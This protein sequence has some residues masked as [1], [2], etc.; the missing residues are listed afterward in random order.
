[1]SP[2]SASKAKTEV[3]PGFLES[4]ESFWRTIRGGDGPRPEVAALVVFLLVYASWLAGDWIPGETA[5][6]QILFLAPV[7]ALVVWSCWRAS[8]RCEQTPWLRSFWILVML[9]WGAQLVADLILG[10][11]DIVL[12]DPTFPSLAD[13]FF[14]CFYPLLVLALLRIPSSP[15]TRSQRLQSALDSATVVVGGG[16]AIWYFDLGH[17]VTE[18][19]GSLLENGVTIAYQ[20]GDLVLLGALALVL[21]RGYPEA[22]RLPL[23]LV[24]AGLLML[25]VADT[26]YGHQQLHGTYMPGDPVDTLY[27]LTATPFVLAAASQRR[28]DATGAAARVA[29]R[30]AASLR[31]SPLPLLALVGG[32]G[33][34]LGT[35]WHDK[36]FPDLS[37]LVFVLVLGALAVCRQY[38]A[39]RELVQLQERVRTIVESVADGIV[40]FDE[41]GRII[42]VNPAAEDAFQ[43]APGELEGT[44]VE[45]IFQGVRWAEMAPLLGV[46]GGDGKTVI[47][48]RR[49][50]TGLRR[51]GDT[52]PLEMIVTDAQLDGERVLIAVGQDVGER[53]RVAAALQESERRFRGIFDHAGVGIAFSAFEDGRPRIVD[54]NAAFS[55]T[56][57]YSPEELRGDDF[58]LI[59][60]PDDLADMAEMGAAV[61]AGENYIAR[62]LRCL[63][64]DGTFVWGSL[65]V[66][67]LRDDSGQPRFAIGMLEDITRRKE[68]ERVK[69]EFVSVVGHEL[70]TPLTSIRGSLGLLEG[71]V[72]GELPEEASQM[73][74]TAVSN[75][76]RLVRLI[77]DIL[78]IERID[79]GRADLELESVPATALV[80]QSIEVVEAVADE[81]G[82]DL[83]ARAG[84]VEVAADPDR[85]V[86]TLT[87]LIGNAIKFSERGG[88]V[89]VT[90]D[91]D[92]D[93]AVFSVSDDGRGIP[94]DRLGAIFERFTQ[95][96]ASDARE[97]GGTGLGLAI[98]RS[99]VEH[100]GGRI[101]AESKEGV[102]STFRFALPLAPGRA[103]E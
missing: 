17:A 82:I 97:K 51:D 60:H 42:W 2:E 13:L 32:T 35:Q 93:Q 72:M 50:L 11:Y 48:R 78:D 22:L 74:T 75:T 63:H 26:V 29:G 41:K 99:I 85:I 47:G 91:L 58:S 52:F 6:L 15:S 21:V 62:E 27:V 79:S 66:S 73:L 89:E 5:K 3:D 28:I 54:A 70:R 25:I 39:Q 1:M 87:N 65:T 14:L 7:D 83:R 16:A 59:T 103:D 61:A 33:V 81:A 49:T 24:A 88:V 9:G 57:G 4:I 101:W 98:A 18:G 77:N 44:P 43:V 34:L 37:L 64:R 56:V 94:A 84:E 53:E 23:R 92:R 100:H 102:G 68:A 19:S 55:K 10:L 31:V 8:R 96:D 80:E 40:T 71:G 30:A 86:Q 38:V 67:V 76:D 95:V 90:V 36:F 20:V 45:S 69:D 46:G 12:D